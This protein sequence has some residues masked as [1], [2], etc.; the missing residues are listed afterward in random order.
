MSFFC[1]L[2]GWVPI[3]HS[4]SAQ[5]T[6][7]DWK[8]TMPLAG[9]GFL[10]SWILLVP[11]TPSVVANVVA[12]SPMILGMLEYLEVEL[13]LGVVGLGTELMPKVCSGHQIRTE[14][15]GKYLV[16]NKNAREIFFQ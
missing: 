12:S 15:Q 13:P 7:S 1:V 9:W 4:R 8:E 5:G 11:V 16:L 14:G 6:G 3:Y 10:H 2:W